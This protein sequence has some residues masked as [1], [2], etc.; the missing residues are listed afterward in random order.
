MSAGFHR[1]TFLAFAL[2]ETGQEELDLLR[3]VIDSGWITTGPKTKQFERDFAATVGARYAVALNS[4]TAAMHLALEAIG[5]QA[6][7]EVVTTPYT[8]AATAE[9]IRYF[10]A[11]PVLVDVSAGCLNIRADLIEGAITPR[12]RAIMPV[13]T[14][15]LP[16]DLDPIFDI[17]RRHNLAVIEDAAHAFPAQYKGRMIGQSPPAIDGARPVQHAVAF[18]FYATKTITTAEGGMLCT[19]NPDIA[20]RCRIMALHGISRDAWNRYAAEGSWFYEVIAPGFKYN[21]TDIAAAMG[22]AQLAKA[23]RM[24]RRRAA[25]AARFNSAFGSLP[26]VELPRTRPDCTHTWHLYMLRLNLNRLKIN[27]GQF[28]DAL[29]KRNIGSSVHFIPLHLHPYY[30]NTYGYAPDDFPVAYSEYMREI[31]LPIYSRMTNQDVQD[32]IDAVSEIVEIHRGESNEA[33][34]R[35]TCSCC[36]AGAAGA[37]AACHSVSGQT[38]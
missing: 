10:N 14:A 6:G 8:F 15:G 36:G 37:G 28:V 25:I 11:K 12:T 7:D 19:D 31:S 21:M 30:R 18:S 5:L 34:V 35:P 17:A 27:R 29:K 13:H 20:E 24:M 23:D 22:L 4:A 2:P 16:A 26:E 9:V 3:E 33:T 1:S 32:V 38:A